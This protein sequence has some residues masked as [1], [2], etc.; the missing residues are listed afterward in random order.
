MKVKAKIK[1]LYKKKDLKGI[2]KEVEK[3]FEKSNQ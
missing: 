2:I 3:S 1:I